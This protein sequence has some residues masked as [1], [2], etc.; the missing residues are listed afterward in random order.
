MAADADADT[1]LAMTALHT[2]YHNGFGFQAS[3][4]EGKGS[5]LVICFLY[6]EGC[7]WD[8]DL[9]VTTTKARAD[10][11][12][13]KIKIDDFIGHTYAEIHWTLYARIP[14]IIQYFLNHGMD[15]TLQME[16][17]LHYKAG[18]RFDPRAA[19]A[20]SV[21]WFR[22]QI[23]APWLVDLA[24][25]SR[26]SPESIV[27]GW[28]MSP[29][30]I[31][32]P[33]NW[34]TPEGKAFCAEMRA[35]APELIDRDLEAA[36]SYFE[37]PAIRAIC[38]KYRL[39]QYG[40]WWYGPTLDPA[41]PDPVAD[42]APALA[43]A[44]APARVPV[45]VPMDEDVPECMICSDNFANTLVLPCGHQVVCKSCSRRLKDT[46]DHHTCVRCRNPITDVLIDA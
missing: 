23:A 19:E 31:L 9:A 11:G 25:R 43:P 27:L 1:A 44:P 33:W 22:E 46:P 17:K 12:T 29:G 10:L 20:Q 7:G 42:P 38:K 40:P 37:N 32:C 36:G 39:L 3:F 6:G 24:R 21:G 2:A 34:Q 26:T 35:R 18:T 41:A 16:L 30:R 14:E 28:T 15:V 13:D 8:D 5:D 45:P 4:L